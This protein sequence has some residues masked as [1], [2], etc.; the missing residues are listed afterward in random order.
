MALV[1]L[2]LSKKIPWRRC[3]WDG[4]A[5]Y[6]VGFL[7]VSLLSMQFSEI[8]PFALQYFR[9]GQETIPILF[10]M[11][12][13]YCVDASLF[14]RFL[15]GAFIAFFLVALVQ[16]VIAITQYFLQDSLG[17]YLLGEQEGFSQFDVAGGQR[18]IFDTLFNIDRGVWYVYRASGTTLHSNTLGSILFLAL[19][20]GS[21][22]YAESRT[23]RAANAFLLGICLL[24]VALFLSFSRASMI[25]SVM[26]L[27]LW[28]WWMRRE[29]FGSPLSLSS[30]IG[31]VRDKMKK[32]ASYPLVVFLAVS[33]CV[34]T[35]L[36]YPAIRGRGVVHSDSIVVQYAMQERVSNY[37]I[38]M[39][40]IS[41]NP[42]LGVGYNSFQLTKL[43][44]A[45]PDKELEAPVHNAY[46]HV[47]AERGI[48]G[49]L[50]YL[51]FIG[52]VLFRAFRTPFNAVHASLLAAFLGFLLMGFFDYGFLL[53]NNLRF[54]FY[55]VAALLVAPSLTNPSAS[56]ARGRGSNG[57]QTAK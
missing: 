19:M 4:P 33:V 48:F 51:L 8:T 42:F 50:A 38:A 27:G 52:T 39:K 24:V 18:W 3:F 9:L 13:P 6:L 56:G 53:M 7:L 15:R 57:R 43:R 49:L 11:L 54:L 14:P 22:F 23:K 25:A 46:L 47:M 45:P 55:I 32:I 30:P 2:L 35:I 20:V 16:S 31:A 21:A 44:Y 17:L 28:F 5:K 37:Q 1:V 29:L 10:C 12:L 34:C 26:G 40:M 36:F 41:A